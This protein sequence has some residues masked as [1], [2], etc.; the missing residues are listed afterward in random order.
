MLCLHRDKPNSDGTE[1]VYSAAIE[2]KTDNL[3]FVE[4]TSAVN[5]EGSN[6]E[7]AVLH[8]DS[9]GEDEE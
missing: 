8:D 3:P 6:Q 5:V 1:T 2:E 7:K 9:T 4:D